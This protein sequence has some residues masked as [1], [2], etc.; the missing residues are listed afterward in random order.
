MSKL[1]K[2]L[3]IKRRL[4]DLATGQSDPYFDYHSGSGYGQSG[5]GSYHSNPGYSLKTFSGGDGD[6]SLKTFS[7]GHGSYRL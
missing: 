1:I 2:R 3:K 6:Y 4:K 5:G 7:G